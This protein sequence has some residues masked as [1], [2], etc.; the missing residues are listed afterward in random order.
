MSQFIILFCL[1]LV[2]ALTAATWKAALKNPR[3]YASIYALLVVVACAGGWFVM[4]EQA[5]TAP[6]HKR[7]EAVEKASLILIGNPNSEVEHSSYQSVAKKG[8]VAVERNRA[9]NQ[10]AKERFSSLPAVKK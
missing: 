1:V 8:A 6:R 10:A 2:A 4:D 3:A 9:E 7:G 5:E